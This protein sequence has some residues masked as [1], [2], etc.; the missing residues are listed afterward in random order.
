MFTVNNVTARENFNNARAA[1]I[2]ANINTPGFDIRNFKLTQSFLRLEQ[3]LTLTNTQ[4]RFPVLVTE[5]PITNNEQRLNLQDSFVISAVRFSLVAKASAVDTAF[6][7]QTYPDPTIFTTGAAALRAV[8]NAVFNLSV[9]NN[10]L[11]PAWPLDQHYLA[12]QTQSQAAIPDV[13]GALVNQKDNS[14]DGFIPCEPNIILVGTKNNELVVNLKNALTAVDAN[15]YL[16]CEL[17]G[18]LAQN[19]TS[20]A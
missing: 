12:P 1:L 9:N 17:Y 7:A 20:I 19:S 13:S 3:L 8:Y 2:Q 16:Q 5:Q 10:M 4:L 15:T 14:T 6:I 18:I 11:I